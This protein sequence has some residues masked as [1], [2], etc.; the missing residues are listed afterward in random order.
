MALPMRFEAGPQSPQQGVA[1]LPGNLFGF[2]HRYGW[3]RAWR[4]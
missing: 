4:Q 1:L 3:I 2:G